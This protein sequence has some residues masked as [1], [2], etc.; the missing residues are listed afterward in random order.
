[1]EDMQKMIYDLK[2]QVKELQSKLM[3]HTPA[4]GD[5]SDDDKQAK[6]RKK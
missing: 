6:A 5:A 3:L 1:M 4:T 2:K